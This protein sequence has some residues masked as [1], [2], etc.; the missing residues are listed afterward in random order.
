[1]THPEELLAG[2]VDGTLTEAERAEVDAHLPTCDLCREELELAGAALAALA[3]L[4]EESVPFGVTGPVLAEAG[5]RF[6]RRRRVVWE[7]F[8]WAAGLAAA[9]ALVAVVALSLGRGDG[10]GLRA[11]AGG[12]A[13]VEAPAAEAEAALGAADAPGLE[14]QP[15]VT[16]DE[17][18]IRSL[19]RDAAQAARVED[20]DGGGPAAALASPD[21]ALDCLRSS[22]APVDEPTDLLVRLIQARYGGTPAFFAVLLEGPGAGQPPDHAVV[23]VVATEDCR[24]LITA[25]QRI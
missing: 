22:G 7:R 1:M 2:Y 11:G 25:S 19:A 21:A 9:A 17:D 10:D 23:W 16:Y 13:G 14:R 3:T 12:D 8:Q 6:E 24:I 15:D 4:Q 5:R 20:Q 18:G